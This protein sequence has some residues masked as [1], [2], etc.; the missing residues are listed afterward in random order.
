MNIQKRHEQAK[1]HP[2]DPITIREEAGR[3]QRA[4]PVLENLRRYQKLLTPQE[5]KTI[6]G[7]AIAGDVEGA[8]RGLTKLIGER[9]GI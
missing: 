9:G 6:R 5:Y 2:Q 8:K 3:Y 4:R 1:Q 7:Q